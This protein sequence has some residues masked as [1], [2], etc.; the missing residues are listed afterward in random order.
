MYMYDGYKF[1]SLTM[2]F[3]SYKSL[4]CQ[5]T[6]DASFTI[7]RKMILAV[8]DDPVTDKSELLTSW[9]DVSLRDLRHLSVL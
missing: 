9:S 1:F 3:I 5:T 2:K 6:F 8:N 7:C 4:G